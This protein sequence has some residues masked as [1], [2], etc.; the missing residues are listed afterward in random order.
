MRLLF[1]TNADISGMAA[2]SPTS[3]KEMLIRALTSD[4]E[5]T[6]AFIA[7]VRVTLPHASGTGSGGTWSDVHQQSVTHEKALAAAYAHQEKLYEMLFRLSMPSE[8]TDGFA[9]A[10]AVVPQ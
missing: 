7:R 3:N 9:A 8:G 6:T 10:R 2:A 5:A 1:F 4:L